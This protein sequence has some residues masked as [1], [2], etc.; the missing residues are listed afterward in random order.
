M[1]KIII[2]AILIFLQILSYV[3][4]MANGGLKFFAT[5][6][7]YEVI[8]FV[9]FNLIGIIGLVLLLLGIHSIKKER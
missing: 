8:Y 2:G 1:A 6:S 9:S 5:F 7:I 3:G 4:N